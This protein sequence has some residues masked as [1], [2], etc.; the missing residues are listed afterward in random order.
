MFYTTSNKFTWFYTYTKCKSQTIYIHNIGSYQ[1]SKTNLI[2][3]KINTRPI[4]ILMDRGKQVVQLMITYWA[5]PLLTKFKPKYLVNISQNVGPNENLVI[6]FSLFLDNKAKKQKFCSK[7]E[8]KDSHYFKIEQMIAKIRNL[9]HDFPQNW[10]QFFFT[11]P[12]LREHSSKCWE[13]AKN[14]VVSCPIP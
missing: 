7:D 9:L 2:C 4:L 11:L 13:Q 12:A 3:S 10:T 14:Y 6:Y 5:R 1:F 8:S